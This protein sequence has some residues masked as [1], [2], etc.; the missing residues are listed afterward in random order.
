MKAIV[1]LVGYILSLIIAL[2][3]STAVTGTLY[4]KIIR[5][6]NVKKLNNTLSNVDVMGEVANYINT[7]GYNI[8][9]DSSEIR[10]IVKSGKD[11]D[12]G[13]Y[14]YANNIN[15]RKVD[16]EGIFINRLHEG[17]AVVTSKIVSRELNGFAA[18]SAAEKVR[19]DPESFHNILTRVDDPDNM[20]PAASYIADNYIAELYKTMIR[21]IVMLIFLA[22]MILISI[23]A[24]RSVGKT[25]VMEP[26]LVRHT[27]CG[28]IGIFKGLVIVFAIAVMVRLYVL[29]GS[30]KMMFFNN[31]TIENTYI[32]RYIYEFLTDM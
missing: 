25:D 27:V 14:K 20:T 26:G 17:Y 7:L 23:L 22:I 9:V 32:F 13:I 2:S 4:D 1:S 16:E 15:N 29:M 10:K 3:I 28:I 8:Y 24:A 21:M 5:D 18:D 30:N 12:T 19:S 6:S 11:I 31:D